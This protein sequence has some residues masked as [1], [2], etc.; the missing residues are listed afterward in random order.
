MRSSVAARGSDD[1]KQT[2][3]Q[4]RGCLH[5]VDRV[6]KPNSVADDHLSETLIT[7]RLKRHPVPPFRRDDTALHAGKDLFVA[8]PSRDGPIPPCGWILGLS[9]LAFLCSPLSS[10]TAG[11]TRYL[12]PPFGGAC[13]DF[14]L[15]PAIALATAGNSDRLTQSI[16]II[17]HYS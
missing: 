2:P 16:Y 13:S 3:A 12:F 6:D 10:R 9:A 5:F 4:E 8:F 11:V 17:A 14:P 1:F 15:S 7:Q